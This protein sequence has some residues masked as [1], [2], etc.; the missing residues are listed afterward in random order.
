MVS[1]A[2]GR[3]LEAGSDGGAAVSVARYALD[4][5]DVHGDDEGIPMDD[6]THDDVRALFGDYARGRLDDW[7][8]AVV[9]QHLFWCLDCRSALRAL[10]Q[11]HDDEP[12]RAA[13]A[14]RWWRLRR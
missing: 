14:R 5:V 9:D 4:R 11:P 2:S 12:E 13:P 7:Q 6:P 1:W 10:L 3:V 8:R